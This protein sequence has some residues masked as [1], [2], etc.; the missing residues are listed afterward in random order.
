MLKIAS[1]LIEPFSDCGIC[2]T[3]YQVGETII[4]IMVALVLMA[5]MFILA[6]SVLL[7]CGGGT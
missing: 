4:H 5:I 6:F 7:L 1:G 3:V 2:N